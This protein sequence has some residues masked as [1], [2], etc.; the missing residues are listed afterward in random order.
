MESSS[1]TFDG[2]FL[3]YL[4]APRPFVLGCAR[5]VDVGELDISSMDGHSKV[6][7]VALSVD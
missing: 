4:A 2:V 6:A 1:D 7:S 3:W 5:G